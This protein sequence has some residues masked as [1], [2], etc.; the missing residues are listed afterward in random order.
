MSQFGICNI[1]LHIKA[2]Q[3]QQEGTSV[4]CDVTR[5]DFQALHVHDDACLGPCS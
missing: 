5:V 1:G 4:V 2:T 3:K